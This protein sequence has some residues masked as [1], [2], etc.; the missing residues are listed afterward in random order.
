[1]CQMACLPVTGKSFLGR[2][3]ERP[4]ELAAEAA[5]FVEGVG[6]GSSVGVAMRSTIG[7]ALAYLWTRR[8]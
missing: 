4:W 8:D 3:G 7:F 6:W 2:V 5:T 1:M